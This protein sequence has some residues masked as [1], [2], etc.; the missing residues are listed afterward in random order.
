ME[1]AVKTLAQQ[2]LEGTMVMADDTVKTIQAII[3][4]LDK[5]L[6]E[7]V[8]LIL[9]HE[10]FQK[11]EG[12][13]RGLHYLVNN[14]ETDEQLKIRVFNIS[15]KNWAAPSKSSRVPLRDQSPV[16]KKLYEEE[17]GQ[18]GGQPYG[19]I[20]GDYQFDQSPP[21]IEILGEMA[22]IAAAA[23]RP[24]HRRRRSNH[25]ANGQLARIEQSREPD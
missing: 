17:Y 10:D 13:W 2:A 8:N 21:D 7:Q 1:Q 4:A 16:F 14:T 25:H 6:T 20:C 3:A 11:L 9:H 5:K 24:V 19:C 12:S 22:K 15:K 23:P 18:F